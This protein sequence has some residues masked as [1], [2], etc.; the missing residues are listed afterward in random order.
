[1][2]P[3]FLV[4]YS[5]DILLSFSPPFICPEVERKPEGNEIVLSS[6]LQG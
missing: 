1:M 2:F 4:Y 6:L 5:S 3:A